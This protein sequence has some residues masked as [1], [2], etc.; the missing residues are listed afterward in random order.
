[1]MAVAAL[2]LVSGC[3]SVKNIP[4][5]QNVE[6]IDLTASRML[7]DARIMPKDLLTI[8]INTTDPDASKPFNL[9]S[10]SQSGGGAN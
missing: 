3:T 1:M 2:L 8:Y 6:E 9:Y 5:L 4:Y 10:Q 7:Y